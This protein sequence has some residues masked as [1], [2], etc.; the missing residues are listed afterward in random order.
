[1][2]GRPPLPVGTFGSVS[3]PRKRNGLWHTSIRHYGAW[4]VTLIQRTGSTAAEAHRNV[5]EAM[6]DFHEVLQNSSVSRT[7]TLNE[8]ARELLVSMA[9]D[10]GCRPDNRE[11][12][13]RE[14]EVPTTPVP[15]RTPSRSR[16]RSLAGHAGELDRRHLKASSPSGTAARPSSTGQSCARHDANRLP[17]QRHPG[18]PRRRRRLLSQE[19]PSRP[20]DADM[21]ALPALRAQVRACAAPPR[22][23]HPRAT[24]GAV[25]IPAQG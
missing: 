18:P 25:V 19:P 3:K 7:T 24:G 1:M 21:S 9:H 2:T 14:I 20:R 15:T 8:L 11:S 12:H 16:T 5:V 10:L 22:R 17:P 6:R 13:R 23:C 4:R